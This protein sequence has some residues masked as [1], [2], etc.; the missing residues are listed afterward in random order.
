MA[1]HTSCAPEA[2]ILCGAGIGFPHGYASTHRVA[3]YARM[4]DA[5]G[6]QVTV[7][8]TTWSEPDAGVAVNRA[9][10]GRRGRVRFW[11][12]SGSPIRSDSMWVRRA[13]AC[14]GWLRF[15]CWYALRR[16]SIVVV[17]PMTPTAAVLSAIMF[18]PA[19]ATVIAD[20]SELPEVHAGHGPWRAVRARLLR[21]GLSRVSGAVVISNTLASIL[22]AADIPHMLM[23]AL[24]DAD[25]FTLTPPLTASSDTPR[26]VYTGY[27]NDPKDGVGFLLEA[28]SVLIHQGVSARLLLIGDSRAD[29]VRTF[30]ARASA[31]GLGS[32]VE[33]VGKL[34]R[35][36]L[37]T[38]LFDAWALVLPRPDTAQNRANMPTKLV[39]YLAS[40]RPV[41]AT[42]VGVVGDL[43]TSDMDCLIVPPDSPQEFAA[44][45][46]YLIEHSS[47]A[48][49]IGRR[50]REIVLRT[51]DSHAWV[52]RFGRFVQECLTRRG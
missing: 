43:L 22:S 44:A 52:E 41:V 14:V 49:A 51:L 33:F 50:G 1:R 20:C 5:L 24:I 19:G 25:E 8:C 28:F 12:P 18:R 32:A 40:G 46:K 26:I 31:L 30:R 35:S 42:D 36:G 45:I 7:V 3:T 2:A 23:P 39:E 10:F 38:A 9:A 29:V 16:P 21:W 27:L 11:Y 15:L 13:R 34:D 48:A 47:E 6:C 4:F 17:Y 37:R